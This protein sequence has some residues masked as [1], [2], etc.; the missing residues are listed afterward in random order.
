M[1]KY[2][3]SLVIISL[4][5]F[6]IGCGEG[7]NSKGLKISSN[8]QFGE[9]DYQKI[10]SANNQLG[11]QLLKEASEDE[12]GNV[13][14]SPM[15][16]F[17]ALSML[18]NGADG[19]TKE[20][21]SKVLH[22]EGID[23]TELNQANASLMSRLNNLSKQIQLN[24]ANSIW[25]ND[26]FQFQAD[27]AQSNSDYFNAEIQEINITDS[28]SPEKINEWVKKSTN[29]KID[30]IVD[31]P[32]ETELVAM[33]IN[34]IYFKGDWT[35][36]FDKEQT[37]KQSFHL[38]DGTTKDVPLMALNEKLAYLENDKFQAV[39]L[40]YGD[41]AMSM[42]VFLPKENSSIE[43]LEDM[44]T[45]GSWK[46]WNSAFIKQIG[47]ILLPKFQLEFEVLL[48]DTLKNLGMT[49]AFEN[50]ANFAKMI[51]ENT[52]LFISEVKQKTLIDVNEEGT[53]AAAVTSVSIA[54][55]SA[56]AESFYMKVNRPFFIAIT[57]EST[58]A[59]LFMGSISNPLTVSSD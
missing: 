54:E 51:Q 7:S 57:E 19:E 10:M 39:S 22:V 38:K 50:N 18:Y 59:I 27:F 2:I 53:E 56:P 14:I 13:F 49:T 36:K 12:K 4:L 21:I 24:V 25:L 28:K 1:K 31:K 40:P 11:F 52:S 42:K 6:V 41:E 15:S 9:D 34:A 43:E 44:L 16:L 17:M 55:T 20:E 58:G 8:A 35:H 3:V 26:N 33:L 29:G 48:N 23:V 5:V 30:R 45:V 46:Q 32:L 37:Q 47:T